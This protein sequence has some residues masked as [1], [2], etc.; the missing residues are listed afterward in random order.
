MREN[1]RIFLKH[2]KKD[3]ILAAAVLFVLL[4]SLFVRYLMKQ[5]GERAEV[6]VSWRGNEILRTDLGRDR[7]YL[8]EDGSAREIDFATTLETLGEEAYPANHD[9]N[10]MTIQDGRVFMAESNCPGQVCISMEPLSSKAYDIPIV[11]LPHGILV[12]IEAA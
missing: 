7:E 12:T 9:V 6:V 10:L 8:L 5:H 4:G 2:H 1:L 11:C 3:C